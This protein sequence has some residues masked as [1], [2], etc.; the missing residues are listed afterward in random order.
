[1]KYLAKTNLT[2]DQISDLIG[3]SETTTFRRA[4]KKWT[5][6]TASEFRKTISL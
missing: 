3:F 4:F 2:I 5:G 6:Q 1:M